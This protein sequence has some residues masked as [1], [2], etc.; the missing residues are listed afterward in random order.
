MG[1]EKR[2]KVHDD[3]VP[4]SR[5]VVVVVVDRFVV[6]WIRIYHY[7]E[8]VGFK[9][10]IYA[11]LR[12]K[13]WKKIAKGGRGGLKRGGGEF[14][15]FDVIERETCSQAR[16]R[17]RDLSRYHESEGRSRR[18]RRSLGRRR[19]GT[20]PL[21]EERQKT[22]AF[23]D[24]DGAVEPRGEDLKTSE[25]RSRHPGESL[26]TSERDDVLEDLE[27]EGVKERSKAGVALDL[28]LEREVG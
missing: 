23:D 17:G 25:A 21:T 24:L 18:E 27:R 7:G 19:R 8:S 9:S 26:L 10:S 22:V 6:P 5:L 4:E 28:P 11:I 14:E 13:D 15:D 16:R 2:L 20:H 1:E 3:H 12:G